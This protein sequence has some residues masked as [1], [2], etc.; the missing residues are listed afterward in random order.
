M[1]QENPNASSGRPMRFRGRNRNETAGDVRP[2]HGEPEILRRCNRAVQCSPPQTDDNISDPEP[3]EDRKR[4]IHAV[5][6]AS[7]SAAADKR[8]FGKKAI[9]LLVLIHSP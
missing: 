9:A 6:N 2:G 5:A 4:T 7:R 3:N 1:N 8:V